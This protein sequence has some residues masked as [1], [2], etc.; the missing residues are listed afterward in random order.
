MSPV[1]ANMSV[2]IALVKDGR[3]RT[4]E[5]IE[6]DIFRAAIEVCMGHKERAAKLLGISRS[7][8]YRRLKKET[9][10]AA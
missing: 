3:Y 6:A 7:T 5:E 10:H 8:M 9:A 4:M 2:S 1:V